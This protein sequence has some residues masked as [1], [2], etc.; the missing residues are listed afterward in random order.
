MTDAATA[1]VAVAR[2]LLATRDGADRT[3]RVSRMR[4]VE[5]LAEPADRPPGLDRERV[6]EERRARFSAGFPDFTAVVSVREPAHARLVAPARQ[7]HAERPDGHGWLRVEID[8]GG[9]DH[10]VAMIW[11]LGPD[12]EVLGPQ[13]LRVALAERAAATAARYGTS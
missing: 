8:F 11:A 2:Y 9:L 3:Y 10:A 1:A 12:A 7:V 6:W 5:E 13:P 4:E